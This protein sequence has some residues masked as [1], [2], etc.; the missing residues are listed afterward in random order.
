MKILRAI[1]QGA[2]LIA[3]ACLV[4]MLNACGSGAVS[5]ASDPAI[6]FS[7]SPSTLTAYSGVPTTLV[8]SGGGLRTPFVVVSSNTALIPISAQSIT[9]TQIVFTPG[10]VTAQQSATITVQDATGAKAVADV[11]ILPNLVNGDITVTGT[12]PSTFPDCAGVGA[13][14]AGQSGTA[15]L[16]VSQ[17][18]V[19]ARGRS[20]RFDVVQGAFRFP[21]DVAQTV[22]ATT[23]TA[24]SDESGRATVILRADTGASPQIATIRA[25]D[26]ATGAFRTATFFI[27]QSSVGG[28]QFVTV[29]PEWKVTGTYKG[30]CP[31]GSVDYLI[32]GG[33]PPYTIRSSLP[34]TAST[35]P[36]FPAKTAV[37]NPSRFS[38]FFSAATCG[39]T[40]YQVIFTV[41]DATGLTIQPILTV[42][43]GVDDPPVPAPE[44]ILSPTAV[45]LACKQSAQVLVTITNP[46]TTA[47][48]ITTSIGT[49]FSSG[50]VTPAVAPA[51]SA[52]VST[53]SNAIT[54]TRGLGTV[55]SDTTLL[56]TDLVD[57]I[58]TVGAGSAIPQTIILTSPYNCL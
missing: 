51:L 41:T 28:G 25:T 15:S 11:T 2:R 12:A 43:P 22:F 7:L 29:P 40:G 10:A 21:V 13:V 14:C 57:A 33:T 9:A 42:T 49:S 37:E 45:T 19:P 23:V 48:T 17:N 50:T 55:G 8:I 27:K 24:T 31:G 56:A 38:A 46:G 34:L 6:A 32:F 52:T 53:S 54:L 36:A 30:T 3:G 18:G 1:D 5:S 26:V 16:T 47:P 58:V 35:V 4:A 44:I 20:V 39:T